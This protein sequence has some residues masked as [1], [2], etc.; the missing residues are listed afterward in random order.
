MYLWF[1][2]VGV[3]V[4]IECSDDFVGGSVDSCC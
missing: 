4:V 2:L 3:F 1:V